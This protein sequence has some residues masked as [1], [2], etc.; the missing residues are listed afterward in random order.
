[1]TIGELIHQQRKSKKMT[2]EDLSIICNVPKSTVSRWENGKI[3]KITRE[4]Q[5]KL[6]IALEIDPI[7]FFYKEEILSREEMEIVTAFRNAD[8]RARQDALNMLLEH[9]KTASASVKVG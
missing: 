4:V 2:I 5:E 9:K 1:M 8:D 6:C 3:K 7:V